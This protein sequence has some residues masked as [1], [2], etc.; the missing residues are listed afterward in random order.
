MVISAV[1]FVEVIQ[2][3]HIMEIDICNLFIVVDVVIVVLVVR[4]DIPVELVPDIRLLE[5]H[6]VIGQCSGLVCEYVT[7]LSQFLI[8][9]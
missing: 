3:L 1:S 2:Q 6:H 5:V 9:I 4:R 7:Y 8:Q